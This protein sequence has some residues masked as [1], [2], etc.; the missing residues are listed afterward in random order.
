MD[1]NSSI[2][3]NTICKARVSAVADRL[4]RIGF[5]GSA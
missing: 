3:C 5:I 1:G 4:G 2:V